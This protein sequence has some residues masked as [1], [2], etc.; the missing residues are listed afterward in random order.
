MVVLCPR[1]PLSFQRSVSCTWASGIKFQRRMT[2]LYS[3]MVELTLDRFHFCLNSIEWHCYNAWNLVSMEDVVD[4][5]DSPNQLLLKATRM[6]SIVSW[7]CG[8]LQSCGSPKNL[9]GLKIFLTSPTFSI[10]SLCGTYDGCEPS[11]CW[12][13]SKI[14]QN[15]VTDIYL[16][17]MAAYGRTLMDG[18]FY[19]NI[20]WSVLF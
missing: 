7:N 11:F 15:M 8:Y 2:Y 13:W 3:F 5:C 1:N 14:G 17:V 18:V 6:C 4:T 10:A 9:I 16:H 12:L 19:R 20:C